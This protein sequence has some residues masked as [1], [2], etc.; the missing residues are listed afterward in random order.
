M[1]YL[2]FLEK[3]VDELSKI[4]KGLAKLEVP[5]TSFEQPDCPKKSIYQSH[6]QQSKYFYML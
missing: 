1:T 3:V 5:V 4:V 2:E 6:I